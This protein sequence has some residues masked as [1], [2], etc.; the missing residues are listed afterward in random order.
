MSP[1]PL[2]RPARATRHEAQ[3]A[4]KPP[5]SGGETATVTQTPSCGVPWGV[6]KL[7]RAVIL[8]MAVILPGGVLLLPLVFLSPSKCTASA[9]P[10]PSH[11]VHQR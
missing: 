11:E 9:G 5:G 1:A 6:N 2:S 7:V 3:R 8:I 10:S 4:R